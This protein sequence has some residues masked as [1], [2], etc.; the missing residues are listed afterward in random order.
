MAG[1]LIT[2]PKTRDL[3]DCCA[4]F[5]NRQVFGA[6]LSE[7]RRCLVI[8]DHQ[9]TSTASLLIDRPG[10]HSAFLVATTPVSAGRAS[11]RRI[12]TTYWPCSPAAETYSGN[13][14]GQSAVAP[15]TRFGFMVQPHSPS[16]KQSTP[17]I[18][19]PANFSPS[20]VRTTSIWPRTPP[21]TSL[22]QLRPATY[23]LS[24]RRNNP[25]RCGPRWHPGTS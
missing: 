17:R 11:N 22:E 14:F 1:K 4:T 20:A 24:S 19:I 13:A 16:T 9:Q 21:P 10:S 3:D 8:E 12:A 25:R 18:G 5:S 6:K 15:L 2:E 7:H 23:S